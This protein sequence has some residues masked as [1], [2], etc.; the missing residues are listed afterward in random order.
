[1]KS[2]LKDG[3]GRNIVKSPMFGNKNSSSDDEL[4]NDINEN[5]TYS[6]KPGNESTN[7]PK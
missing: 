3:I 5:F 6:H 4:E 2:A 1:M 7:K